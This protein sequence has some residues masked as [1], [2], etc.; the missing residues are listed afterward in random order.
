MKTIMIKEYESIIS[1]DK[2]VPGYKSLPPIAFHQLEE[3]VLTSRNKTTDALD[4]MSISSRKGIGTVLTA[5]NYVGIISLKSGVVIEI[6]PKIY[7][8]ENGD[9]DGTK[10][11]RL[12]FEMLRT[13]RNV[14][15]KA[16]QNANVD[17]ENTNIFEIFIRMF[18]DE[19]FSITKRGLKQGY[20]TIEENAMF[21]KGKLKFAQHIKA[22]SVHK[23]RNYIEYDVFHINR[24]ENRL[25]KS[26]LQYLYKHS[27]SVKNRKDIKTLLS[28][29]A[30]VDTSKN[31]KEDFAKHIPNRNMKDYEKA[32]SWCKVFLDGKSF[33]SFS[34][35]EI[36]AALLFPMEL[37]FESYISSCVKKILPIDAFHISVQD[38]RYFLICDPGYRFALRPDIVL[39]RTCDSAVFVLDTKWKMLDK[40]RHN[41]GISQADMY[42]MYVYQKKYGAE[43]V[44]LLY[45]RNENIGKKESFEMKSSDGMHVVV[46]FINMND[47]KGSI[48]QL[49]HQQL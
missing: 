1:S 42:Q 34:G 46:Y 32:L 21:F 45:P 40:N 18:L 6:L 36:A 19:V 22:N 26:T 9:T 24:P 25:I 8:E 28:H 27:S 41:F 47:V 23:E 29:F 30:D 10:A 38:R 43:K 13:L 14:P 3:F 2:E 33:V 7:S 37:L 31:Y 20:E 48:E 11:K 5:K 35:S 15:Y 12:L 49:I 4:I 17:I 39:K 16:L 44:I